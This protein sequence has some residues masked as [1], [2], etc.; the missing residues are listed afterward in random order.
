[1]VVQI[2]GFTN[3]SVGTVHCACHSDRFVS[4]STITVVIVCRTM[5]HTWSYVS[6][7]Y[8][9]ISTLMVRVVSRQFRNV[10][11]PI[12]SLH[13]S[14]DRVADSTST[15]VLWLHFPEY[16][17]LVQGQVFMHQAHQAIELLFSMVDVTVIGLW[18]SSWYSSYPLRSLRKVDEPL[19]INNDVC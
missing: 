11:T 18:L 1:M 8:Q 12:E 3:G 2:T 16:N 17:W 9:P 6:I 13:T 4:K 15:G 10:S 5:V 7:I 19:F 14:T